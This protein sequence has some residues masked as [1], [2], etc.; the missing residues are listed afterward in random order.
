LDCWQL[1]HYLQLGCFPL[2]ISGPEKNVKEAEYIFGHC[3]C[4]QDFNVKN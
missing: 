2:E 3:S 1:S 4:I